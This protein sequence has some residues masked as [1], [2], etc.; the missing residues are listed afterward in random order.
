MRR[1]LFLVLLFTPFVGSVLFGSSAHG[2]RSSSHYFP[3]SGHTISEPFWTFWSRTPDAL[4]ILG[5]PISEPF[6]QA[7]FSEPGQFFRVQY[8]ERA[9][10]EERPVPLAFPG[11][12]PIVVARLLGAERVKGR[13]QEG[14]FLPVEQ[15]VATGDLDWDPVT[16][17]TL[18]SRPAPFKSFYHS[19][20]GLPIFGRP[21]SEQF[22]ERDQETGEFIWVQY[23]ER[24]RLEWHPQEQ[25]EAFRIQLGRLGDEYRAVHLQDQDASAFA[26][27]RH[28]APRVEQF[29]Y[30]VNA[31]LYYTERERTARIAADAGFRWMRQ[32]VLWRAH[33]ASDRSIAWEELDR[34]VGAVDGAG[35]KLL[36]CVVQAPDWAT[37]QSGTTGFP[38]EAHRQDYAAFVAAISA[39]YGDKVA[40]YEIW[41][42]MNLASENGG[43]PVP[44]TADYVDLLVKAYTAIKAVNPD[45]KVISG[46]AGPTEWHRGRDVAISDILFYRELFADPRFWDHIDHVG[47]HVFGYANPPDMLW[48][49]Q[50]GPGPDWRNSR[51]FYFRRVEAVRAEV[52]RAGHAERQLWMTEFGWA[53][54]NDSP[55]HAFGNSNSFE[56]QADYLLRA[57]EIGRYSYTPWLG[58]MFLWNLNFAV[59]WQTAGNPLH[60]QAAYGILDPDWRPRA[61]LTALSAM[62]KP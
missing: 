12:R 43:R 8:F 34:I 60:E 27:R 39:R 33:E 54:T 22:Q 48:P 18:A 16:G 57:Y 15:Q 13:E 35:L 42:E 30:G 53:T 46:G 62:P 36:L 38:D 6:V 20:G 25:D 14:P 56:D 45:A 61:A 3:E 23:F 1:G 9:I 17:H 40:A 26:W 28:D 29:A 55:Q 11:A 44:P 10:L 52:V 5:Y 37:G 51:E 4:R 7:S 58:A 59:T 21:L 49:E 47:V 41:N 31:T 50:P 19:S 24:Q 2:Q 32:Q